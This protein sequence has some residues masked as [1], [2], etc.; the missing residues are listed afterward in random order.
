MWGS[1]PCREI[2]DVVVTLR[3]VWPPPTRSRV[4]EISEAT[5]ATLLAA[6]IHGL[7]AGSGVE[8]GQRGSGASAIP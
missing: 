1:R 3:S 6:T 2:V 4:K 5:T 7:R 8:Q